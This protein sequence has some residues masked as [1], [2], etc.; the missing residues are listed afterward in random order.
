MKNVIFFCLSLLFINDL[1]AQWQLIE[2][3]TDYQFYSI[4]FLNDS[5]GFITGYISPFN[6]IRKTIDYG[7][8]WTT[9]Y[10]EEANHFYDVYFPSDSI[11]YVS[12]YGNILKTNDIGDTWFYVNNPDD[13]TQY[14]SIVFTDNL[15]GFGCFAD[16]GAEFA[17]TTDG[18]ISWTHDFTYG[19][20]EL[21]KLGDCQIRIMSNQYG[22]SN[23]CWNSYE[24]TYTDIGQRTISNFALLNESSILACGQ[25]IT[26][27]TWQNF[28]FII[29]SIDDG[30][31]WSIQ[32]FESIYALRS[33]V[34]VNET[35]AY[36]VGQANSPN[37][38]SFLK[39]ID[40][41]ETWLFQEYD[42]MCDICTSPEIRDI[43]CPSENVC[44]AIRG[45]GGIWRTF[46]GGGEMYPLP[47]NV[48]E[49]E[50]FEVSINPNPASVSITISSET[51]MTEIQIFN[52]IGQLVHKEKVSGK[53]KNISISELGQG[54]YIIA[55]K[56]DFGVSNQR[57]VKQ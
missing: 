41:G 29:K 53:S 16:G 6:V 57:F 18:G 3:N 46:N 13:W 4:F 22:K 55:I 24:N 28:G 26:S 31:S 1:K 37:P 7:N 15:T 12:T 51:E 34:N 47:T 45:F 48:S 23:D 32:D 35:T 30:Q 56:S 44:Y 2:D 42:F 20:R 14:R 5:T 9:V 21:L 33:V 36:C 50:A 17:K 27:D 11:G 10:Q 19:G 54:I 40:G 39:T 49:I 52:S 25:G 8:T 43:Y 38:Y